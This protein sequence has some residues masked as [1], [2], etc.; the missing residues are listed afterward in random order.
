MVKPL[1]NKNNQRSRKKQFDASKSLES[2]EEQLL[3]IKDYISKER[4]NPEIISELERVEEKKADI[5]KMVYKGYDKAYDF[6]KFK[7]MCSF[8]NNIRNSSINMQMANDEQNIWQSIL[9]NLNVRQDRNRIL[10]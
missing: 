7:T 4:L 3:S 2:S 8:G 6:R 9:K 10:T 1:K 5:S